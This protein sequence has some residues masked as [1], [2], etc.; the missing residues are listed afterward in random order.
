MPTSHVLELCA[1]MK[2]HNLPNGARFEYE[3]EE[4]V[5]TGPLFAAGKGGQRLIPKYA[6]LKPIGEVQVEPEKS[7]PD[8]V[9]RATVLAAVEVFYQEC[10]ALVPEARNAQ[11]DAARVRCMNA[12]ALRSGG[13][14]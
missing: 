3:G 2:I 13:L 11:I 12:I 9:S 1:L 10:K 14:P 7:V 6:V 5:K 4:Y 8:S